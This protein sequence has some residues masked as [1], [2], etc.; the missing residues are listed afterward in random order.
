LHGTKIRFSLQFQKE[1]KE[2]E[3]ESCLSEMIS[4]WQH[5]ISNLIKRRNLN[6]GIYP[7]SI[8]VML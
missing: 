1:V 5:I 2:A 4:V 6:Y 3:Y 7:N 8:W